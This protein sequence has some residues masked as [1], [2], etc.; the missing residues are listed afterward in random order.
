MV[1]G[2]KISLTGAQLRAAR[3][4][5]DLS[6]EALAAATDIGLRTI[7]RAEREHGPVAMTA[8]NTARIVEALQA[9][10]VIFV[11]PSDGGGPGVRLRLAPAPDFGSRRESTSDG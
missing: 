4:L 10:G 2:G 5:L 3:A 6:A 1:K 8:A 11:E 9:R 7:G